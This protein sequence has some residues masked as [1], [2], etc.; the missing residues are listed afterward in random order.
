M[1]IRQLL[2]MFSTVMLAFSFNAFAAPKAS[3]ARS[4]KSGDQG[5][6]GR[7]VAIQSRKPSVI[8]FATTDISSVYI[9]RI[10]TSGRYLVKVNAVRTDQR[11]DPVRQKRSKTR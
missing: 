3:P 9:R 11:I 10:G 6:I 5:K 8:I 7:D 4:E 1:S 2:Q